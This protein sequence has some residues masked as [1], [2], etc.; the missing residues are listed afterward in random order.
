[1]SNKFTLE[2]PYTT[3]WKTGYIV[4]NGENRKTVILYNSDTD[5]TSTSY[6]RYLMAVKLKKFLS[7]DQHVDHINSDK[8]DDRIENLQV[9]SVTENNRKESRRR[10]RVLVEIKCPNCHTNFVRRKGITQAT[11][12]LRGK[13]TCCSKMCSKLFRAKNYNKTQREQI[14]RNSIVK[15]FRSHE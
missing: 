7:E 3:R 1:M 14:S 13:V 10:G 6:A 4:T 12:S 15:E 2:Y 8:T 9:L 5:R 11:P